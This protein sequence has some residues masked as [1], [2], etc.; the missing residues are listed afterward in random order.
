MVRTAKVRLAILR[1][2]GLSHFDVLRSKLR[3]T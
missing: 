2:K 1:P 3:W